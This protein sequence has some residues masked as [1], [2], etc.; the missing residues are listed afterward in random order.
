MELSR[1]SCRPT[2]YF[3]TFWDLGLFLPARE[4]EHSSS[5]LAMC[6]LRRAQGSSLPIKAQH[7]DLS[8]L[9]AG[10]PRLLCS[11]ELLTW[12]SRTVFPGL[13]LW[14][15]QCLLNSPSVSCV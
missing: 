6:N 15:A 3:K 7:Q 2:L 1:D 8:H 12:V 10:C 9:L 11:A 14:E 4:D 5:P 13:I